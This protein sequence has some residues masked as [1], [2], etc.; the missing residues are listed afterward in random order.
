MSG[1]KVSEGKRNGDE[2]RDIIRMKD[3]GQIRRG[4]W[5]ILGTWPLL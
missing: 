2:F 1:G 3:E 5:A 4:L